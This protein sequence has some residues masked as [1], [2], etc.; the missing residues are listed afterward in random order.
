MDSIAN[1]TAG[2]QR[3]AYCSEEKFG[4]VEIEHFDD[5]AYAAAARTRLFLV[6]PQIAMLVEG[7]VTGQSG[8]AAD[9]HL[10][11]PAHDRC[12]VAMYRVDAPAHQCDSGVCTDNFKV[13]LGY[14]FRQN[15]QVVSQTILQHDFNA[16]GYPE[17]TPTETVSALHRARPT[18]DIRSNLDAVITQLLKKGS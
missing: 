12:L 10:Q 15:D 2:G 8:F 11:P 1:T 16:S 18:T 3:T 6:D 5:L 17:Q 13:R 7:K 9:L 14:Q 4:A